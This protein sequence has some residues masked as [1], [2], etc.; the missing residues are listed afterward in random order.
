MSHTKNQKQQREKLLKKMHESPLQENSENESQSSSSSNES[1]L[2]HQSDGEMID[3]LS[4]TSIKSKSKAKTLVNAKKTKK[5]TTSILRQ[6]NVY[7]SIKLN[8][9]KVLSQLNN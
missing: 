9:D 1:N 6:S 4:D 5:T 3:Y 2:I 8:V 7:Y